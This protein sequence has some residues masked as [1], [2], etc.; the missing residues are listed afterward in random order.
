MNLRGARNL[1]SHS[2]R[3]DAKNRFKPQFTTLLQFVKG[4]VTFIISQEKIH[5]SKKSPKEHH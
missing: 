3:T 2:P 5:Y 1:A 4:N